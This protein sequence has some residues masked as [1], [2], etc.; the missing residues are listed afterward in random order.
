MFLVV[1]LDF[2]ITRSRTYPRLAVG[3]KEDE[4]HRNRLKLN[5]QPGQD[6]PHF[7]AELP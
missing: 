5:L 1:S 6:D 3:A 4:I 7:E 2:T